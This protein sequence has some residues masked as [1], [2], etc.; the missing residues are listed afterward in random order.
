MNSRIVEQQLEKDPIHPLVL[1]RVGVHRLEA[2]KGSLDLDPGSRVLLSLSLQS[3]EGVAQN[4]SFP[5]C[6]YNVAHDYLL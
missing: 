6:H 5:G 1:Y 3:E 2:S 4:L